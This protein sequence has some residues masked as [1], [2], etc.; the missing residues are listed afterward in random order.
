MFEKE[1]WVMLDFHSQRGVN[2]VFCGKHVK[3]RNVKMCMSVKC[4]VETLA[5]C[6][7]IAGL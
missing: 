1:S 3:Q 5:L 7:K 6:I 4:R 2:G